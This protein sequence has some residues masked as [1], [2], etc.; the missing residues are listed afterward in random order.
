[1]YIARFALSIWWFHSFCALCP[2]PCAPCLCRVK[3]QEFVEHAGLDGKDP[4]VYETLH[5]AVP[6][7]LVMVSYLF[8]Y[9]F[10]FVEY[11]P[12]V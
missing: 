8:A 9:C 11:V 4:L 7:L 1:M 6:G 12:Y 5:A 3:M 10:F 2:V